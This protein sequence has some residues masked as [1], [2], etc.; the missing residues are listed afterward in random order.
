MSEENGHATAE[1]IELAKTHEGVVELRAI[2][3]DSGAGS[4]TSD[5]AD[6][7]AL[8][9]PDDVIPPPE[10]LCA[11]ARLTDYSAIRETCIGALSRNTVGLGW[12]VKV[13]EGHQQDVTEQDV[14]D[15]RHELDALARRDKRLNRPSFTALLE[16]GRW[17]VEECGNG[18][19]EVSRNR[20]TGRID[21][22]YH[23][24]GAKV[25]RKRDRSGYVYGQNPELAGGDWQRKD[26]FNFGEKVEYAPD[27]KPMNRLQP[28]ARS[29]GGW[30][31]NE[32]IV[33][34]RYTS[35]SRDYGLP[36]DLGLAIEYAAA[37][38]VTEYLSSFFNASGTPPKMIF[39]QAEEQ[40]DPNSQRIRFTVPQATINRMRAAVKSDA[41]P[42]ARAVIV[43]VP[44]GTKVEEISLGELTD[45]DITFNDFRKFHRRN[46]A[47][48]MGPLSP[49]FVGDVEDAG[50]YTAEVQRSITLE[51]VFDPEQRHVE[52][53]L[54]NTL[55]VDLG[56]S[57]MT[58]KFKRMAV[59]D[60]AAQKESANSGAEYG[61]ITKGEWRRAHGFDPLKWDGQGDDPNEEILFVGQ[62]RGAE[63]RVKVREAEDQRGLRPGIGARVAKHQHGV[64]HVEEAVDELAE[65]LSEYGP[66]SRASDDDDDA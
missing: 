45:R 60:A 53:V 5:D 52:D 12:D 63:D 28:Q 38:F 18:A 61:T 46:V 25:R 26:Y 4:S 17:D 33:L 24:P 66:V 41:E 27:G 22:L 65:E 57:E 19:I 13:G 21:G 59:E 43:P 8:W 49:I 34:R 42:G 1:A 51:Q 48:A 58:L 36:R 30:K 54:W 16:A 11:L 50:R 44:P 9:T 32:L 56:F 40:R 23:V 37:R 64:P 55:M 10:D 35:Q 47:S 20:R 15:A 39:V 29:G 7:T 6:E 62:P 14:S 3:V 2:E 31:R